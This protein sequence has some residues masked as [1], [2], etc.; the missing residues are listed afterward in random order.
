METTSHT[1]DMSPSIGQLA[2]ALA[3]AQGEITGALKDSKNPFFKSSYADLASCWDACRG[4]LS[5]NNLAV[6]QTTQAADTGVRVITMLAHASGEWVRGTLCMTPTKHDPQGIGS[7]ITYARRYALAA[8]V[9][10]AQ[11]DDD[12]NQASG[13]HTHDH[14]QGRLDGPA[15]TNDKRDS[16]LPEIARYIEAGDSMGLRQLWDELQQQEQADIWRLL[17]SKQKSKARE[18]LQQPKEQEAA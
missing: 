3:A 2:K 4:P 5:K 13:K 16:Y 14:E 7:C 9:G 10:L 12:A 17:N 6:I 11:I 15:L 1:T 18:M 8:I